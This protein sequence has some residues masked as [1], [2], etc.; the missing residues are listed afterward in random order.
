MINLKTVKRFMKVLKKFKKEKRE[1]ATR[2]YNKSIRYIIFIILV[3]LIT[4]MFPKGQTPQFADMVEGSISARRIVAPFSFEILKTEDEYN[5]DIKKAVEKVYPVFLKKNNFGEIKNRINDFFSEIYSARFKYQRSR[6]DVSV[7][8]DSISEKYPVSAK[9]DKLWSMFIKVDRGFKKRDIQKLQ[10]MVINIVRDVL[11]VG[12]LSVDKNS[13]DNNDHN[14]MIASGGREKV[15]PLQDYYDISEALPKAAERFTTIYANDIE[16]ARA[17]YKLASYFIR[18]DLIYLKKLHEERMQEARATVPRSS[19]FVYQNEKIVDRNERITVDIRKKLVSLATVTAEKR[20]QEGGLKSVTPFIGRMFFV[21]SIIMIFGLFLKSDKPE[22]FKNTKL[23]VL[24]ALIILLVATMT[25]VIHSLNASEYLVPT[26]L[27][28]MLLTTLFGLNVGFISSAVLSLLVGGLWGNEFNFTVISFI[29]GIVGV[30]TIK[31]VRDRRQLVLVIV[32]LIAAYGF[33]I[34]SMSFLRAIHYKI[35]F[36]QLPF[37]AFTGLITPVVAYGLLPLIELVFGVTTDFSILELSDL[38]HPLLKR[39]SLAAPGTYYHSINVGNLAEA[40]A[41]A[42]KANSLLARVGSYYHDVGKIEKSEYFIEN[43]KGVKNP[44]EKLATRMSAL[45]LANHVKRGLELA[46]EYK[47]PQRIKDIIA[48]HQGTSLMT[49]FYNKAKEENQAGL[50]EEDYRYSGPRPQTKEAAIVMLA[51]SVEAAS[52]SLKDPSHSRLKGLVGKIVD[53]KFSDGELNESPL[54][55]RDLER[56][57]EGF[58]KILAGI[59]H[60]RLEY[61]SAPDLSKGKAK[62][63][64]I[65]EN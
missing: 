32:Y 11:A 29:V 52:R 43:Q 22:I 3:V 41:Q 42:I 56:I 63:L 5:H 8:I 48:Q 59:Y 45:I 9:S 33:S 14:I 2:H 1:A 27:G 24:V 58:L 44:H 25:F 10:K 61:P 49:Y 39:L 23:M 46:E 12:V 54:T 35:I 60:T 65:S 16:M 17:G 21:F 51:D 6:M 7:L 57:K 28:P 53:Q 15:F 64:S 4:L 18:P 36:H 20:K 26:A 62:D 55:L 19:G 38:N 31:R 40:A 47:L 30:I 50:S 37:S 13:I 34:I